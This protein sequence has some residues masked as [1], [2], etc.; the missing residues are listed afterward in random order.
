MQREY[1]SVLG[2]AFVA[3]VPV[4]APV[5]PGGIPTDRIW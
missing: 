2:R 3:A 5:A 4:A 1:D